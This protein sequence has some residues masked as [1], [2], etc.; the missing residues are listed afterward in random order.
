MSTS[1]S[2]KKLKE[3]KISDFYLGKD[4]GK[5]KFGRVKIVKHKKTGLIFCVKIIKKAQIKEN[6]IIDQLIK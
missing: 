5:G 2:F 4:L 1:A 3:V 6:N